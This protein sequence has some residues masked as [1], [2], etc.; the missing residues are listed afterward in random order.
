[1]ASAR[2]ALA[3][4]TLSPALAA[5]GE[6]ARV[7]AE[8]GAVMTEGATR[9]KADAEALREARVALAEKR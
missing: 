8:G 7:I 3:R 4:S 2:M 1:M 9:S 5:A 6:E